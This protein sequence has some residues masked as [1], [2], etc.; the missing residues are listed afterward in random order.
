M[1]R[2]T[3]IWRFLNN[4][5]HV[6]VQTELAGVRLSWDACSHYVVGVISRR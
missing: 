5:L 2:Y 3:E 4:Y 1:V 6:V